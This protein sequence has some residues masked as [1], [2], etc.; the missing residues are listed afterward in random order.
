MSA[1][2]ALL[3]SLNPFVFLFGANGLSDAPY[4]YFLM[5]TVIEFSFWIRERKTSSLIFTGFALA[6][7]FWTGM[8]PFRSDCPWH[9]AS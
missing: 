4:V 8:R 5:Y 9:S 3:F 2:L 7:A 1:T 6:L